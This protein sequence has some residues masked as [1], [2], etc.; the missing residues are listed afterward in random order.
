MPSVSLYS[1]GTSLL[2]ERDGRWGETPFLRDRDEALAFLRGEPVRS[3]SLLWAIDC[4]ER[5][6]VPFTRPLCILLTH[7]EQPIPR[8]FPAY[9]LKVRGISVAETHAWLERVH[10]QEPQALLRLD[11]NRS[12][13]LEDV[14]RLQGPPLDY[15]EEPCADLHALAT[16]SS[17]PLAVDET[18]APDTP[19]RIVYKPSVHGPLPPRAVTLSGHYETGIG[20][21]HIAQLADPVIPVGLDTYSRVGCDVL[22]HRLTI[23][24][25]CIASVSP[26]IDWSRL[27]RI[28]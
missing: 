5:D 10:T 25:G 4:L 28:A 15:F 21:W 20:T 16:R 13:L 8:G 26:A 24:D 18:Y 3:P 2:L 12:W 22:Q 1:C 19:F 17:L 7:P 9:K 6:L 27:C 11:A 14:L 23:G